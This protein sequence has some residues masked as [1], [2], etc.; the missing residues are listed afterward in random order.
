MKSIKSIIVVLVIL[1]GIFAVLLLNHSSNS[2]EGSLELEN[3][4]QNIQPEKELTQ[5]KS[6]SAFFTAQY[7][8]NKYLGYVS[9][10]DS[11]SICRVLD[12]NYI[13]QN[14]ITSENVME[15]IDNIPEQAQLKVEKMYL[16]KIDDN[17]SKY[18][19]SGLLVQD[20]SEGDIII[21][22]NFNISVILDFE[23]MIFSIIPLENGGV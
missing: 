4:S 16:E 13:M 1:I 17:N 23:N 20:T 5:V 22:D 15:K 3:T 9:E 11:E 14:G 10:K 6:A 18:Y 12:Y 8:A 21:Q 19:M 7:C 2:N